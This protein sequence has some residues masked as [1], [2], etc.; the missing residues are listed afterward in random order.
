MKDLVVLIS[1]LK[2]KDVIVFEKNKCLEFLVSGKK[3]ILT[4]EDLVLKT[5]SVPGWSV[6]NGDGLTVALDTKI[7][8]SL[9]MEGVSREFVNRV[10]GLRK[11]LDFNVVDFIDLS[12]F[13]DKKTSESIKKNLNHIKSEVLAKNVFFSKN[14]PI[15]TEEVEI[16]GSKV[17]IAIKT[18]PNNG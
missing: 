15:I 9:L 6:V 16:N 8:D 14:K 7:S 10:Q 2:K 1:G 11:K 18:N 5:T 13:C 4:E 17:Y 12:V 3:I